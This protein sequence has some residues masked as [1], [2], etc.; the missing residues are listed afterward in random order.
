MVAY[1]LYV[2]EPTM[3]FPGIEDFLRRYQERLS[4]IE[5]N[6]LALIADGLQL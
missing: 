4:G 2:P 6:D 3:N 1:E 5:R